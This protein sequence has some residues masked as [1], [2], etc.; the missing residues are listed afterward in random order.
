V[1]LLDYS[2]F[3]ICQSWMVHS[4]FQD[5]YYIVAEIGIYDG[6]FFFFFFCVRAHLV[7]MVWLTRVSS[8]S[9]LLHMLEV[10]YMC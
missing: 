7:K 9:T 10:H 5:E 3:L 4:F 2:I 1:P 6:F 8:S